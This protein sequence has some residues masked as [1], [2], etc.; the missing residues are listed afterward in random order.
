MIGAVKAAWLLSLSRGLYRVNFHFERER[1]LER[2]EARKGAIGK[3]LLILLSAA[4]GVVGTLF[5]QWLGSAAK[6]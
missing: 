6:R 2:E 4:I 1:Q 3:I 5:V